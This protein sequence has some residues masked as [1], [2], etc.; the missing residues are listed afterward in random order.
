MSFA[1]E[2]SDGSL[3]HVPGRVDSAG[4]VINA[5]FD[6]I[7]GVM[8][9]AMMVWNPSTLSYERATQNAGGGVDVA[10][11]QAILT[12]R[13]EDLGDT[14]YKGEAV[15]G[16]S[17]SSSSWSIQRVDFDEN[18]NVTAILFASGA[19]TNRAALTYT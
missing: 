10:Q 2:L 8:K 17:E 15:P 7:E 5:G 19:W 3:K 14:I 13:I 9:V 4:K 16:T 6:E 1:T 11:T 18:G 12:R